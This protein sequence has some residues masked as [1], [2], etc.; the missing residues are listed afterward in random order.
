[1][2]EIGGYFHLELNRICN[3]S[4]YGGILLNSGRCSFE[5]I[6][7]QLSVKKIFLPFYTCEVVLEPI[8]RRGI[9]YEF[10]GIDSNLEIQGRLKLGDGDYVLYTNYFGIKDHY[11]KQ[12]ANVYK[13]CLIIDNSQALFAERWMDIPTFYSPRK[14]VGLP[15]GGVAYCK[16]REEIELDFDKSYDRCEHLLSRYDRLASDGYS[17]FRMN[18]A[19]LKDQKM[20]YMSNLTKALIGNIDFTTVK[21]IRNS[22]FLYLHDRLS[23]SN[24]FDIGDINSF[25]CPMVYPYWSDDHTLRDRLIKNKIYVPTYWPNVMQWCTEDQLEYYLA[26]DIIPLPIDQR[27]NNKDL[28]NIISI[29]RLR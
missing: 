6:L 28:E 14:F 11:V 21:N 12:L 10:Y 23:V 3:F 27:Y 29:I 22:N 20:A 2:E 24:K 17:I 16:K 13:S 18:S 25:S 15:D 7:M 5:Y 26:K 19:K 4:H 1:M 9:K 8:L